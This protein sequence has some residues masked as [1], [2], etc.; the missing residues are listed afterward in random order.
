MTFRNTQRQG[1]LAHR[2]GNPA[3]VFCRP[4][5]LCLVSTGPNI[6]PVL[7]AC[8]PEATPEASGIKRYYLA[9]FEKVV[10]P[11]WIQSQKG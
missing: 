11:P 1:E 2:L 3:G 4:S 9:D 8:V 10:N 5:Q 7:A 6:L